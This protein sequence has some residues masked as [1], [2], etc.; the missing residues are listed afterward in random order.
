MIISPMLVS[1]AATYDIPAGRIGDTAWNHLPSLCTHTAIRMNHSRIVPCGCRGL[2]LKIA[3]FLP[4]LI[5]NFIHYTLQGSTEFFNTG[6]RQFLN[7]AAFDLV[8]VD[9]MCK[10]E[11]LGFLLLPEILGFSLWSHLFKIVT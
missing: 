7:C 6:I 1:D 10:R 3:L 5:V 8:V 2:R 4:Q 9:I 11:D